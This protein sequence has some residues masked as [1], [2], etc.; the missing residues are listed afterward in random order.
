[1]K[2]P[3]QS[4]LLFFAFSIGATAYSQ[5]VLWEKSFGGKNADY[6]MDAQPTADYGFILAGSSLS[7]K[8]G[9]KSEDNRGD[10]DYWIWKMDEKGDLDWQKSIGGNKQDKLRAIRLTNDGGFI[11]AGSSLSDKGLDKTDDCRGGEDFWIVKLNAK[12]GQE[13]Q[14]TIGGS[15]QDELT[16]I[17][18]TRD[19]GYILGGSSSSEISGDKTT[20][21]FGGLD[22]WVIKLDNQGKLEWQQIYGGKYNDMLRSIEPTKDGG[23]IVG[24]YS[25]SPESGNKTQNTMGFGDYWVLKLDD[26]GKV[27]WQKTLGGDKDDQL[28]VVHQTYDNGYLLGGNSNSGTSECKTRGN[29]DGTDF[30]VVKLKEDGTNAWQETYN[31]A[32]YDVMLSMVENYDHSILLGGYAQGEVGKKMIGRKAKA[33]EGTDDFV[34]IKINENGEELW[35]KTIGSDGQDLL[36]KVI[37]TRDGG[38]LL[39]GTSNPQSIP[40]GGSAKTLSG[41]GI[42]QTENKNLAKA[43]NKVNGAVADVSNDVNNSI[44]NTTDNASK[45][46]N[47]GLGLDKD[48]P[49]KL[50]V[51]APN[52]GLNLPSLGDGK[53]GSANKQDKKLPASGDKKTN[54]G[55]N[56]FWVV[57]LRDDTKPKKTKQ[58][59]EAFPNPTTQFTNIIVNHEYDK[60]TATVYDLAGRQLQSFSITEQTIPVDLGTL[61][62]GIYIVEIK[63]N[64]GKDSVKIIK[65]TS[66]N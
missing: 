29:G 52:G 25:N 50:G 35:R 6:L 19:G 64:K 45:K 65:G 16:S 14:K 3:V 42:T 54:F 33:V 51:N 8:T 28:Y 62:Q 31:I 59:I 47:D 11:L 41:V 58:A 38:Y 17:G 23:F 5:D 20:D 30:W 49:V 56:D 21:G 44:K 53:S 36:K 48:S 22:Y 60:G 7:R 55:T 9:N 2:I 57:K 61:P 27:Q 15:G 4:M 18:I 43:K 10:L 13:W 32:N 40:T 1:M 39:A 37:E 66:K 46:V 63:T 24:G 34:A 26:A 12:G